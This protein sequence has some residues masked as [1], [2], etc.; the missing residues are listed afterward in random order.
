MRVLI[1]LESTS[2][3]DAVRDYLDAH[4]VAAE[5]TDDVDLA[6]RM[7][8]SSHYDGLLCEAHDAPL[9]NV[10]KT[11]DGRTRTVVLATEN[12][13]LVPS[14]DSVLVKPLPLAAVLGSLVSRHA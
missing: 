12:L 4:G 6:G 2:A 7:L 11:M 3:A 5:W 14:V 13:D 9:A 10:A 1:C 8:R